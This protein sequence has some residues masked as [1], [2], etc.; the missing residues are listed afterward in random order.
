MASKM[1]HCICRLVIGLHLDRFDLH[2]IIY[3]VVY[4]VSIVVVLGRCISC[5][6]E[7][8]HQGGDSKSG[9]RVVE[10]FYV[11]NTYLAV[12]SVKPISCKN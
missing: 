3:H 6:L 1:V 10:G 4:S 8:L 2:C 9:K 11:V 5:R 12:V 7:M